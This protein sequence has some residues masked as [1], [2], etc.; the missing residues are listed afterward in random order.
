[1]VPDRI[2]PATASA[3]APAASRLPKPLSID[4]MAPTSPS[5][6]LW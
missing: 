3:A 1:M 4:M 2:S 5:T 6:V